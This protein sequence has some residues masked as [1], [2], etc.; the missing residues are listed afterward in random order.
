M[1][2]LLLRHTEP[3]FFD[4]STCAKVPGTM[5]ST[6]N[7]ITPAPDKAPDDLWLLLTK[8]Q[9]VCLKEKLRALPPDHDIKVE[10]ALDDASCQP[11]KP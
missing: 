1:D 6:P 5:T 10:V 7:I 8:R 11:L 4:A 2:G 3:I 9:L